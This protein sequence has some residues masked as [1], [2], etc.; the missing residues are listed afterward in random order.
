MIEENVKG[1]RFKLVDAEVAKDQVHRGGG[2]I[3]PSAR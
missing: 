3:I 1:V 2:Q